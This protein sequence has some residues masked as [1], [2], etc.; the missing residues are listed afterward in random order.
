[1]AE[2]DQC[3]DHHFLVEMHQD[4][5]WI[6]RFGGWWM[7]V[8]GGAIVLLIPVAITFAVYISNLDRR[9]SLVEQKLTIHINGKSQQ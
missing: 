8:T 7:A 9:L 6:K 1:M 5:K 4:L 2:N 3:C